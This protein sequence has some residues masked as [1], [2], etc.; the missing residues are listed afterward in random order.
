MRKKNGGAC[1]V[2]VL[3][4]GSY[5]YS[6]KKVK[7]SELLAETVF[8]STELEAV[9]TLLVDL[10]SFCIKEAGWEIHRAPDPELQG[11][12]V[13]PELKGVEAYF[14]AGRFLSRATDRIG[15]G[16]VKGL[17]TECVRGIIQAEIYITKYRGFPTE[18][19]YERCWKQEH[20]DSCR[21]YKRENMGENHWFAYVGEHRREIN[22]F[23]RYKSMTVYRRTDGSFLATGSFSDSFHELN[24][25]L[26]FDGDRITS[27]KAAFLRAPGPVCIESSEFLGPFTGRSIAELNKKE[28]AKIIGGPDGCI[29]LVDII[30][31]TLTAARVSSLDAGQLLQLPG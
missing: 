16:L 26:S 28:V 2:E 22:L 24:V 11:R 13:L 8:L 30:H 27:C 10:K 25:Q 17:L 12:G 1:K 19:E 15:G 7:D 3:Y 23:N 31:D 20:V 4:Q 29:H 14:N 18:D 5:F 6:V 21:Y 9:G